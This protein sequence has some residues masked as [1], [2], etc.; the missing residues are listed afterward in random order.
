MA[1]SIKSNTLS[2]LIISD[3]KGEQDTPTAVAM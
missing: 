3:I 2:E 1:F